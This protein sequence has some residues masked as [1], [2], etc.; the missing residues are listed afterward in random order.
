MYGEAPTEPA[1]SAEGL[2]QASKAFKKR[3][4]AVDGWHPRHYSLLSDGALSCLGWLPHMCEVLGDFPAVTRD[5]QVGLITAKRRPIGFFRCL[6]K[7][8]VRARQEPVRRWESKHAMQ[9][10]FNT[11]PSRQ[12][13]DSVWRG[14]VKS[15]LAQGRGR[16]TIEVNWD[17]SKCYEHMS[18]YLLMRHA[19]RTDY[20]VSLLRSSIA[21]YRFRRYITDG[22]IVA[23]PV[24]TVDRAVIAG[25]GYAT[26]EL[27]RLVVDDLEIFVHRWPGCDISLHIDD[28]AFGGESASRGQLVED[29]YQQGVELAEVI[30]DNLQAAAGR[31]QALRHSRRGDHAQGDHPEAGE[32]GGP[33]TGPDQEARRRLWV[34][35]QG[36]GQDRQGQEA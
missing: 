32:A 2:R 13:T 1:V 18:Y 29:T 27:K 9:T 35:P 22:T 19:R 21:M 33:I 30:S 24:T 25:G 26:Y 5:V 28:L 8:F 10:F 17:F 12:T 36:S 15:N 14:K 34:Q 11:G 31:G 7:L 4:C 3:T 20:P 6:M 23:Q 16:H